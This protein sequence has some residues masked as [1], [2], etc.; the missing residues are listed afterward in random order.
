MIY[1]CFKF[2][3]FKGIP[4]QEPTTIPSNIGD[5]SVHGRVPAN[6]TNS[7]VEVPSTS[8]STTANSTTNHNNSGNGNDL[9]DIISLHIITAI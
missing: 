9:F 2:S 5:V 1:L 4:L 7:R 6:T 8:Q 3:N